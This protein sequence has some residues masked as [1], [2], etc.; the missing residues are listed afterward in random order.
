MSDEVKLNDQQL[1][2]AA[3]GGANGDA[4]WQNG[5]FLYR[6]VYGDTLSEIAWRFG[7]SVQ[8]IM[9]LNRGKITNPDFIQEGWII[10]IA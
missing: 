6:V 5:Q 8:A 9:N 2:G 4:W 7:T 3:G 10:R 1:E